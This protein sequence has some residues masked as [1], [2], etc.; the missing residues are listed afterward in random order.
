M[1]SLPLLALDAGATTG[2]RATTDEWATDGAERASDANVKSALAMWRALLEFTRAANAD[3]C[4][5]NLEPAVREVADGKSALVFRDD[6]H[7]CKFCIQMAM[8]SKNDMSRAPETSLT[9]RV[10]AELDASGKLDGSRLKEEYKFLNQWA[11]ENVVK[12]T[13]VSII[14]VPIAVLVHTLAMV[15]L[16]CLF[17]VL[18]TYAA[19]AVVRSHLK[20]RIRDEYAAESKDRLVDFFDREKDAQ[21]AK[22]AN[23]FW[24]SHRRSVEQALRTVTGIDNIVIED[25]QFLPQPELAASDNA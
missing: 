9:A 16:F 20:E 21:V 3:A 5:R 18:L 8:C 4:N 6:L 11:T 19:A 24:G 23:A 17:F 25:A 14:G 13:M 15:V 22:D 10:R 1:P 12:A 7:F 2:E